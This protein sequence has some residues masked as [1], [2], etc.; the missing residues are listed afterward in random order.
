MERI[1]QEFLRKKKPAGMNYGAST[2]LTLS[3]KFMP[4]KNIRMADLEEV[5]C[6][7]MHF[8]KWSVMLM[9]CKCML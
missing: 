5:L 3:L 1:Y 7:Q 4:D 2:I 9:A 8:L 6:E